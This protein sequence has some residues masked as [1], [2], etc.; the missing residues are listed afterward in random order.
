MP[1]VGEL[2]FSVRRSFTRFLH[3]VEYIDQ[4][5]THVAMKER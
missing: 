4:T 3:S 5:G 2:S 1:R